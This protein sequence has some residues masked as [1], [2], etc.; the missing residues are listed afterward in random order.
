MSPQSEITN[1]RPTNYSKWHRAN[2]PDWCYHTDGD[3]FQQRMNNGRL[4]VVAYIETIQVPP[5]FIN[6]A[7]SEYP[8]WPSKK[9]LM[10]DISEAMQIPC[11]V[12]RHTLDCKLFSLSRITPSGEETEAT[13]LD[14]QQYKKFLV[15]LRASMR[16][17]AAWDRT[18]SGQSLLVN[19]EVQRAT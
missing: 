10:I 14:E 4:I 3:W 16:R 5:L 11:C 9:A 13:V 6:S 19:K 17:A 2:L 1:K 12:V 18:K 7:Q 15:S 8:L